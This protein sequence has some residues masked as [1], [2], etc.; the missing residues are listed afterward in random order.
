LQPE[1]KRGI[2]R[3]ERKEKRDLRA[4]MGV[5]WEQIGGEEVQRI[6]E[7]SHPPP[8]KSRPSRRLKKEG[9]K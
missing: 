1:K 4:K 3:L 7:S 5:G 6:L 8:L 2:N 9:E